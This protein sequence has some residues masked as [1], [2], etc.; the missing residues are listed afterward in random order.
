MKNA[1]KYLGTIILSAGLLLGTTACG[2]DDTAAKEAAAAQEAA[3]EREAADAK[4]QTAEHAVDAIEGFF[5]AATSDEIAA[6]FPDKADEKTFSAA[7][8]FTDPDADAKSVAV[9]MADLALVK[10]FD[11]Q[12]ELSIKV[13]ES[14]V[15]IKDGKATVPVEAVSV[16]SGDK[17]VANSAALADGVNDLVFRDGAWLITF[18]EAPEAS[19]SPS[20]S[21][22]AKAPA[23]SKK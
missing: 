7:V 18:P 16:L 13:D 10:V 4:L 1:T 21:A 11:A 20:A 5:N 3:T 19:A 6:A 9:A 14:K 17:A 12:A 2:G 22:E 15:V 8:Q 23:D